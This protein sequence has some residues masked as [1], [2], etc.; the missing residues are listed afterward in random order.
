MLINLETCDAES[1][2]VLSSWRTDFTTRTTKAL[3]EIVFVRLWAVPASPPLT[4]N[5]FCRTELHK[6]KYHLFIF[7]LF[8]RQQWVYSN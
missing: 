6:T 2:K 3:Y 1:R 7:F 8:Y 5:E 4:L